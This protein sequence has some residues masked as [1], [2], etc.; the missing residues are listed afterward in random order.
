M[1]VQLDVAHGIVLRRPEGEEVATRD[2]R[3]V[4]VKAELEQIAVTQSWY[5]SRQDGAAP[6]L[7]RKHADSFYV[8]EGALTFRTA[9]GSLHAPEGATFVAPP[10]VVHGFDNDA[11]A[12]VRFLNFHTPDSGFIESMRARRQP[13]TY[14]ATRY[15]SWDPEDGAPPGASVTLPGDGDR[16][17]RGDRV[18]TITIARDE[19]SLVVFDLAPGFNGPTAHVHRRHVDSFYVVEGEPELRVGDATIA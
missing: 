2:N 19:L 16:L 12:P 9:T 17:E 6:H 18:A 14:D 5:G 10:G 4:L 13:A 15:D 7:H 3:S 11:D 1:T 8:L